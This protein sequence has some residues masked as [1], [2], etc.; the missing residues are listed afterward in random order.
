MDSSEEMKKVTTEELADNNETEGAITDRE[1]ENASAGE[2][3][4]TWE[5]PK[6]E[7]V[8]PSVPWHGI[9][10]PISR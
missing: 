4:F 10:Q 8:L 9:E 7:V 1:A 6:E 5:L 3:S 2:G